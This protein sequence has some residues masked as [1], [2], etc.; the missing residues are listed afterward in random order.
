[1]FHLR[2]EDPIMR[3]IVPIA[4]LTTFT[5]ACGAGSDPA[6]D[7]EAAAESAAVTGPQP[8]S[9]AWKIEAY[10]TAAPREISEA[11]AVLDH[12]ADG[13]MVELRA[14]TNGWTCMPTAAPGD[15]RTPR[16]AAPMCADGA[17]MQW[18]DALMAGRTPEVAGLGLSYMLHGDVGASNIDPAATAP[19]S[20][21]EWIVTGP[22]LMMI[23]PDARQLDV[24]PADPASGG[25]Y[26]MWKGTPW[27]HIMMPVPGHP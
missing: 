27:A 15:Y 5:V 22:H 16:E 13:A 10:S 12:G 4:F 1:M 19:T 14:G 3:G 18:L 26:V 21:N 24:I 25:P 11:A 23:A 8:G 20:D 9:V 6:Y 7:T 17:F 2:G